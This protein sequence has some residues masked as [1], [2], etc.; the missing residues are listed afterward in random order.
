M[1]ACCAQAVALACDD[2]HA[3]I[4][5]LHDQIENAQ[6]ENVQV[7]KAQLVDALNTLGRV[8]AILE[9]DGGFRTPTQQRTLRGARALLAEHGRGL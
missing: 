7:I 3:K 6:P 9:R 5:T 8:V 4:Q 1:M 2:A